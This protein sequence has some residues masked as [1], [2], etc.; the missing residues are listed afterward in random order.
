MRSEGVVSIPIP[1]EW[2]AG[3]ISRCRVLIEITAR[4]W[5]KTSTPGVKLT[6]ETWHKRHIAFLVL[7]GMDLL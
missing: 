2:K 7:D 4:G 6:Y 3:R 1:S 5:G